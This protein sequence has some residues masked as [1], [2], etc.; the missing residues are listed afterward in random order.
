MRSGLFF[1][2][3]RLAGDMHLRRGVADKSPAR[4]ALKLGRQLQQQPVVTLARLEMHAE[5]QAGLLPG[6]RQRNTGR[7]G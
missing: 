5:R 3:N 6:Q 1:A 2:C 7:A 4:G